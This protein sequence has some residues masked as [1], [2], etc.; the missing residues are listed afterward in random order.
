MKWVVILKKAYKRP[1]DS[2]QQKV[3]F[4]LLTVGSNEFYPSLGPES[5]LLDEIVRSS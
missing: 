2:Q 5:S 3:G 1:K 4:R